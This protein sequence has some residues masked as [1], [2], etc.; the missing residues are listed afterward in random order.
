MAAINRQAAEPIVFFDRILEVPE[1][2]DRPLLAFPREHTVADFELF[3]GRDLSLLIDR[4]AKHYHYGLGLR[5][6]QVSSQENTV[7]TLMLTTN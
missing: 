7:F 6:S 1:Y 3:T 2:Q 4:A 5:S